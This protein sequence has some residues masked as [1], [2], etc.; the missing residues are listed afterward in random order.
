MRNERDALNDLIG[1]TLPWLRCG[2][3]LAAVRRGSTAGFEDR[4]QQQ[5]QRRRRADYRVHL[6]TRRHGTRTWTRS[7]SPR[8]VRRSGLLSFWSPSSPTRS[9]APGCSDAFCV[10]FLPSSFVILAQIVG[11]NSHQ[12]IFT[13]TGFLSC[14]VDFPVVVAVFRARHASSS[15]FSLVLSLS[16]M[17]PSSAGLVGVVGLGLRHGC[18]CDG[19]FSA[20]DE[21]SF[22]GASPRS[23]RP[24]QAPF[25]LEARLS[26]PIL[27]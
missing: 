16:L 10:F 2:S 20:A 12:D 6:A 15:S 14:A 22:V 27:P 21:R 7:G 4:Q 18:P 25:C 13:F 1:H 17:F 11:A 3:G 8:L 26:S 24:L 5:Q 9:L 23:G 19:R